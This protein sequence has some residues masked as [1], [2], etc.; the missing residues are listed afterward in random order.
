MCP[1]EGRASLVVLMLGTP[2]MQ[3]SFQL[4][5]KTAEIVLLSRSHLNVGHTMNGMVFLV[6][7]TFC[8]FFVVYN[9][10]IFDSPSFS[11]QQVI[12]E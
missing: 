11:C 3:L 12:E 2:L 10:C 1:L 5:T 8:I 7:Y 4:S 6:V 9:F